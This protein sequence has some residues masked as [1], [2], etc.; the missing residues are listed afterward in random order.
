MFVTGSS[1][2]GAG[3]SKWQRLSSADTSSDA[4]QTYMFFR[5]VF[6]LPSFGLA[7]PDLL[8][9]RNRLRRNHAGPRLTPRLSSRFARVHGFDMSRPLGNETAL[10]DELVKSDHPAFPVWAPIVIFDSSD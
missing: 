9:R 10:G 8:Q 5:R 3:G 6:P 1:A 2:L 4:W 7:K